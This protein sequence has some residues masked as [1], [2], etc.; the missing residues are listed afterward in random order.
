MSHSLPS[1]EVPNPERGVGIQSG[2]DVLAQGT[3]HHPDWSNL[4][5][6]ATIELTIRDEGNKVTDLD[7]RMSAAIN[8]VSAKSFLRVIAKARRFQCCGEGDGD[9]DETSSGGGTPDRHTSLRECG[10]VATASPGRRV[11]RPSRRGSDLDR[12]IRP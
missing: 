11:I 5:N 1:A 3:G 7:M 10:V 12:R 9:T 8:D 4:W 2:V 6:K